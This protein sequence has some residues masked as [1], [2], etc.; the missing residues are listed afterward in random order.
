MKKLRNWGRGKRQTRSSTRHQRQ[1]RLKRTMEPQQA[2]DTELSIFLNDFTD[3][4]NHAAGL[5]W[6]CSL[7][8]HP[9]R[10][11]IYIAEPRHV[12]LGYYMTSAEFTECIALVGKL[13][14]PLESGDPPLTTVLAG[15]MTQKVIDSRKVADKTTDG[16]ELDPR[17][18]SEEERTLLARCI[19]PLNGEDEDAIQ[20]ARLLAMDFLFTMRRHCSRE[21]DV[22]VDN[23][24][25]QHLESPINLKTHYHEELVFRTADELE[26]FRNIT[27]KPTDNQ[28]LI[29]DRRN[30]LRSW[31][32]KAIRRKLADDFENED[33]LKN[34]GNYDTLFNEMRKYERVVFFGGCSLTILKGI[35]E[36]EDSLAKRVH[37][38]QQGGTFNSKLNILGNPLNFAL[39]TKA[40]E[41]VFH[42]DQMSKLANFT[43]VPT[44]TTKKLEFTVKGLKEWS[45]AIGLHSL[46]FYG[47]MDPWELISE[48][49][50][51]K[52]ERQHVCASTQELIDWRS[53]LVYKK[54]YDDPTR[55]GYK[56]VMADLVAFLISFTDAF[57]EYRTLQKVEMRVVMEHVHDGD[58][59]TMVL[60]S[61]ASSP[62]KALLLEFTE[63]PGQDALIVTDTATVVQ[64]AIAR[65]D[66]GS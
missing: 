20:H 55:K 25:L 18:L 29:E 58:K 46:G 44:D 51:E 21:F 26:E 28:E 30:Q 16:K 45:A 65:S 27:Q 59:S 8:L 60:K 50:R 15:R 64:S 54:E 6:A 49:E 57:N 38:Y 32:E 31:Y 12:N 53:E 61:D 33:P 3:S 34:L 40:A 62:I 41:F 56:A 36:Q 17:P 11:G 5:A 66:N 9:E 43:L 48:K 22:Y 19:K 52:K 35:L 24:V 10:R 39:N 42:K 23:V 63:K 4:D 13:R 37:Y 2:E 47:R 1:A 14:P 7:D